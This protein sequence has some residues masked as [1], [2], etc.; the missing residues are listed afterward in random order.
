METTGDSALLCEVETGGLKELMKTSLCQV[1]RKWK[2]R[3][4]QQEK[5]VVNGEVMK[6]DDDEKIKQKICGG[7]QSIMR[8]VMKHRNVSALRPYIH[9]YTLFSKRVKRYAQ[10]KSAL[11]PTQLAIFFLLITTITFSILLLLLF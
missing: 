5:C 3:G 10:L 6:S 7:G 9:T 8:G 4:P 11:L 1:S 2:K